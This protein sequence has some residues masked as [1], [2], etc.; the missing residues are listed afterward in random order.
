M[1]ECGVATLLSLV[2]DCQ[3]VSVPCAGLAVMLVQHNLDVSR[4]AT[5]HERFHRHSARVG[6]FRHHRK[7]PR[8]YHTSPDSWATTTACTR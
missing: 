2:V 3:H 1:S 4:I 6:I 8:A 5:F 7:I